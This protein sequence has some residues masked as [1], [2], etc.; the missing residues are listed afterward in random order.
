MIFNPCTA[1]RVPRYPVSVS[2]IGIQGPDYVIVSR[3][4]AIQALE[5]HR[6]AANRN[7]SVY[8]N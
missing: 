4:I 6:G 3:P 8:N 5:G 1:E 2:I 7:M